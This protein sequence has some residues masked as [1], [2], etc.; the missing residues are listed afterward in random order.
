[1]AAYRI[2]GLFHVLRTAHAQA[3]TPHRA[4]RQRPDRA[5]EIVRRPRVEPLKDRRLLALL[6]IALQLTKPDIGSGLLTNLSY[7]QVGG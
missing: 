5:R 7:T 2:H 6:G 4:P 3:L 1:L